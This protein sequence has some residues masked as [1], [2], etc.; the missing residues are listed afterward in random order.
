MLHRRA[1]PAAPEVRQGMAGEAKAAAAPASPPLIG[2]VR[3]G[4]CGPRVGQFQVRQKIQAP[5]ASEPASATSTNSLGMR[6]LS[7]RTTTTSTPL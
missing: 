4:A 7:S 1:A 6:F 2:E 5:A 3:C